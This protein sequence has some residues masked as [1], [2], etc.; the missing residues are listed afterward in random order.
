MDYESTFSER[1]HEEGAGRMDYRI[2]V[3]VPAVGLSPMARSTGLQEAISAQAQAP[4]EPGRGVITIGADSSNNNHFPL[5]RHIGS[6]PHAYAGRVPP[7]EAVIA[8]TPS[9]AGAGRTAE[10]SASGGGSASNAYAGQAAERLAGGGFAY[11]GRVAAEQPTFGGLQ[12]GDYPSNQDTAETAQARRA[13]TALR[14]RCGAPTRM[15]RYFAEHGGQ[16]PAQ[17]DASRK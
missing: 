15:Q 16:L 12:A 13:G 4:G 10:Q 2:A 1:V 9:Y 7:H 5:H 8:Q 14:Q 17:R 3:D 6:T 11:T